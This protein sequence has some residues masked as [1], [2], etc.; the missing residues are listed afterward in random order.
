V[1]ESYNLKGKEI[2]ASKILVGKPE[3]RLHGA[4]SILGRITLRWFILM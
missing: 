3:A 4:T 2:N 1:N